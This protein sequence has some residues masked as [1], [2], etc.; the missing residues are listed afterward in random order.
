MSGS[1]GGTWTDKKAVGDV[2]EKQRPAD[3]TD[4]M[5]MGMC[6]EAASVFLDSSRV[7]SL[8]LSW[9]FPWLRKGAAAV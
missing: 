4:R 3:H 7:P 5:E 1:Q 8:E 9:V 6:S 2:L